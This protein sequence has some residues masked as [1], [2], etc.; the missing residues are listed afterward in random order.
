MKK[1]T[2]K[3]SSRNFLSAGI[4]SICVIIVSQPLLAKPNDQ[5]IFYT[6][7]D[8][9]VTID[10]ETA[11]ES[12][13]TFAKLYGYVKYFHPSDEAS[14]IDWDRFAIYGVE[15]VKNAASQDD[16]KTKLTDL[17]L[18]IAPTIQIYVADEQPPIPAA[19]LTPHD[20]TGLKL[21]A[22]QHNGFGF[23]D[24]GRFQSI[25]LNRPAENPAEPLFEEHP[26][27]G[28][29]VDRVLGNDLAAQIPL[30]L[31]SKDG[32]T[33]RPEEAPSSMQ[34]V[35]QLK[36]IPF[37]T[38]TGANENLSYA[39]VVI[40]WNVFQHFYPYFDVVN[41][42]WDNILSEAL[43]KASNDRTSED[44]LNTLKWMVVQL[45]D[46]HGSV[47]LQDINEFV[48][49][50]FNIR[51][52]EGRLM[53]TAVSL[54]LEE[55]TCF[56]QGDIIT[57]INGKPAFKWF[58]N[59]KR[60]ISGT[61]QWKTAFALSEL[62]YGMPGEQFTFSLNRTGESINCKVTRKKY[63]TIEFKSLEPIDEISTDIYYV[64]LT[65]ASFEAIEKKADLLASAKGIIFDQR[66]YPYRN[67]RVLQ[68]LS[69]G[70]L[71]SARFM[72]PQII[73]PDQMNIA[74]YD[75]TGRWF[76]E[77][78]EPHFAGK[79]VFL[80]NKNTISY[81]ETVMGIVEHY[82]LG[83]IVG[84]TTAGANGNVT[85]FTLPGGYKVW[86]T[87]MRVVKHDY[88]QH[89]L[90]GIK[91]TVP[92]ERTIE[93]VREDRDKYIEKALELIEASINR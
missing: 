19:I 42:N 32:Q 35:E 16:L 56:K 8:S 59:Q 91:P 60:L 2:K 90:V 24:Y 30:A 22:W 69:T 78:K 71:R 6:N 61:P 47:R 18:P 73:Y 10:G 63:P 79:K 52:I 64:N 65:K 55:E 53:I 76:I 67:H 44:F 85:R 38:L 45:Q 27:A 43:L 29:V 89:H 12:I 77:P 48:R 74:G 9:A 39:N 1:R 88:S 82:K 54:N 4:L 62:N 80:I 11:I 92:V 51:E 34:L 15:Y 81:G 49:F 58:Q 21:V 75:T 68:F 40:A 66:G 28:E 31:F 36:S 41:V 50:P 86:W 57:S 37:D 13:R 83:E 33:L 87:G 17:F 14:T 20:T 93:G 70:T 72:V 25:R 3:G 23:G 46:G 7:T 84:E 5:E 26:A